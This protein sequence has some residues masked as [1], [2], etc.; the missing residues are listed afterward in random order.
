MKFRREIIP[1]DADSI[2]KILK[3]SGFFYNFE[4]DSGVELALDTISRGRHET[5]MYFLF[6]EEEG[7]VIGFSCYGQG[8]CSVS[9]W[10][11]Y[12]ICVDDAYRGKGMGTIL[13]KETEKCIAY[14]PA[15][16]I[17]W[18]ETSARDLYAP[19]RA[20]YLRKGYEEVARLKDFYNQGDDK[21]VYRKKNGKGV[22]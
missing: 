14:Q 20:F 7:K 11:V 10:I 21:I 1:S 4:I 3:S 15:G 9:S 6:L 22:L 18:I 12:W 2:K 17:C 8:E 5:G 19:T 13:L 16:E